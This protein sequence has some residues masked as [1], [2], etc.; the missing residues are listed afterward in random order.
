[1]FIYLIADKVLRHRRFDLRACQPRLKV[2]N[3][4]RCSDRAAWLIPKLSSPVTVSSVKYPEPGSGESVT[5]VR[6]VSTTRTS[7]VVD[8]CLSFW[9]F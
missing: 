5:D 9:I 6:A 3:L 1:V 7:H 4:G 2:L 8:V